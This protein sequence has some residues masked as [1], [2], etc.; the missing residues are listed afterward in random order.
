MFV[1]ASHQ[2]PKRPQDA[3][4]IW[5][6]DL[7]KDSFKICL[8]ETKIFDGT[9]KKYKNCEWTTFKQVFFAGVIPR[10]QFS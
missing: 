10:M 9:H 3:M 4:T 2:F 8:R 6:E 1:T 7:Q 5:I